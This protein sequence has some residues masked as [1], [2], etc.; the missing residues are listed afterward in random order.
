MLAIFSDG[1][2]SDIYDTE[3]CVELLQDERLRADFQV[4]L[5][6]FFG[7]LDFVLPRPEGLPF[8]RDSKQLAL[9]Q[10]KA[11]SRY[12]TGERL[13]GA[14]V[15]E[16]VRRLID[17]HILSLGVDPKVPPI[18]ITPLIAVAPPNPRLRLNEEVSDTWW[19]SINQL[20]IE[21]RSREHRLV[22]GGVTLKWPAYPSPGGPIW[23]ITER[24]LT[25]FLSLLN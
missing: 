11:R 16:K 21:G 12:R 2:V 23:G 3:A 7:T 14:E 6:Q 13:I 5:K 20:I 8:V 1:G 24:I 9:I 19:L 22:H 18:E 15:G 25:G 17:E 10:A 4:K